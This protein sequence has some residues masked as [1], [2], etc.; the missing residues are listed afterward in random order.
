[1]ARFLLLA[2]AAALLSLALADVVSHSLLTWS[3]AHDVP[4]DAASW[5]QQAELGPDALSE[6]K[7]MYDDDLMVVYLSSEP[8]TFSSVRKLGAAQSRPLVVPY[9]QSAWDASAALRAAVRSDGRI[10]SVTCD[11]DVANAAD[12]SLSDAAAHLAAE[13]N[14]AD[15]LVVCIDAIDGVRVAEEALHGVAHTSVLASAD[16]TAPL[17]L[18]FPGNAAVRKVPRA[19]RSVRAVEADD[20]AV[21]TS[22]WPPQVIEGLLL[23][24]VLVFVTA[25]GFYATMNIQTPE[26]FEGGEKRRS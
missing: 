13:Q 9:L 22:E 6:V 15:V 26:R 16:A 19:A 24:A 25:V 2:C 10:F 7:R 23:G 18:S 12:V 17:Q 8:I 5:A 3:T 4:A 21:Y 14:S 20:G 11:L 1:M